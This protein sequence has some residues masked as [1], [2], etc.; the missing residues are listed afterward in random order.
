SAVIA[1]ANALKDYD[2][3]CLAMCGVCAG[4]RGD[5]ALGDVII[6]DRV[7]Q[8]DAGK[9]KAETVDGKPVVDEQQDIEMY[10]LHPPAWKQAAERF[11]IDPKAKWLD[12]RPRSYEEQGDWILERV[13]RGADPVADADS[14][15]LCADFDK[16]LARLWK[17]GLLADGTLD[18][19][20]TGRK[21]I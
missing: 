12:L 8:Y 4:R 20:E 6:A 9:R 1:A 14:K 15:T 19:T 18:L 16:A 7:W 2:V 13:L 17:K 11:T 5:V 10:R 3:R 21:H